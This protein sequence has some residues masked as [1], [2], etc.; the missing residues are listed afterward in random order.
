MKITRNQLRRLIK[1]SLLTEDF[2]DRSY[3]RDSREANRR[4]RRAIRSTDRQ[5]RKEVRDE[6]RWRK[7]YD[8][9]IEARADLLEEIG[10]WRGLI[11]SL[12]ELIVK[13]KNSELTVGDFFGTHEEGGSWWNRVEILKK[14]SGFAHLFEHK[15]YDS[16]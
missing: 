2:T 15:R 3:R 9:A 16:E 6:Y 7:D 12:V 14:T 5:E 13:K 11:D 4:Y 1:D 10:Q 8:A